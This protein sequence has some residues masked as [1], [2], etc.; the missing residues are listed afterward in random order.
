MGGFWAYYLVNEYNESITL[1]LSR[2]P[3]GQE[4]PLPHS[5]SLWTFLGCLAGGTIAGGIIFVLYF[6]TQELFERM[7]PALVAIVL[8]MMVGYFLAKYVLI[9]Y[10]IYDRTI[11]IYLTTSLVLVFGYIGI[12]LGLSRATHWGTLIQAVHRREFARGNPKLVDTSV[13]IDG[14][15]A[16][17]CQTGFVE[18]TLIIPRFVLRELQNIADSADELRRVRGRRGL[19]ILKQLQ[20]PDSKVTVEVIED[21]PPGI[22]QVDGKLI[23]LAREFRAKILT[24]DLNLNKVAQIDGIE[25]LN[26]NDLANALKPALL[27]DE[28][29]HVRIVKEGKEAQQGVGYLDDGTMVVVDGG[30]E[31]VGKEVMALV[32]SVLQTT[33]GRMIFGKLQRVVS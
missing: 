17:V 18:G 32:T 30:R 16:E 27:P 11:E 5:V 6:I 8:A 24:N 22:E 13:I 9:W 12:W 19:D 3:P 20:Q 1:Q 2:I 15:I 31:F 7:F 10:P 4:A 14:R 25:V 29:L 33:A 23:Q 28:Q 21:D 26:L